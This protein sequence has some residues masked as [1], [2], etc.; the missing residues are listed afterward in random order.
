MVCNYKISRYWEKEP[1]RIFELV[2]IP[3][4]SLNIQFWFFGLSLPKRGNSSQKRK[5]E[6]HQWIL[7]I[8]ISI[9]TKFKLKLIIWIFLTKFVQKG[10]FRSKTEKSHLC[11][12]PL[13]L[14]TMLNFSTGRRQTKRYFKVSSPS[15]GRDNKLDFS[16][17]LKGF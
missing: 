3:N 14:L 5:S 10:N 2:S 16:S 6:H 11:V 17:F 13:S 1:F 4:I 9:G 8:R 15:S 7:H 12:R